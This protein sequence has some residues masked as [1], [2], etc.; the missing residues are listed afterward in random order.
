LKLLDNL[1]AKIAGSKITATQIIDLMNKGYSLMQIS[2][3]IYSIPEIRTAI[4]FIAE[5]AACVP[6]SH[7]R[8][9]EK[10]NILKVKDRLQYVLSTRVNSKQC[11][12]VFWTHAETIR[13]LYN[14]CFIM[15]EWDDNGNVKQMHILPFTLFEFG[16][17]NGKTTITFSGSQSYPFYYDDIIHL[18]R[19][20]GAKGGAPKQAT[21]NYITIA[22]TLQN[23]AVKDSESS[24]RIAALLQV[25]TQ[26]KGTDMLKKLN[27][28]KDLFL[29]A[30]NT[31]GFGMIGGEYDVHNLD[32]KINPLN[33][34]LLDAVIKAIYNYF[35]VSPEIINNGASELQYEQFIDNTIKPII[36]ERE[37]ELSYKLFSETE[38]SHNNKVSGETIDLEIST[39]SAKTVFFDKMLYH[40]VF[41]G[42]EVRKRLGMGR[43]EGLDSYRTNLNSVDATKINNYQGV[44]GGA[45]DGGSKKT[46]TEQASNTV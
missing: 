34:D 1:R 8:E 25:K 40:G 14:N 28:F 6:L 5:K 35:G 20:P 19:F 38:L 37:E 2:S 3:D 46:G 36:Y 32:L 23:Q 45:E 12:Q 9:D 30:E 33:K 22:N 15:P 18:Q 29:S 42:N 21:G 41:N 26:L 44:E 10:G 7:V 27:E 16:V 31:T 4:N 39:L 11:P 43:V 13:L 17:E 24:G